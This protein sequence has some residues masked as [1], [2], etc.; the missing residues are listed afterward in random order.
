MEIKFKIYLKNKRNLGA[1][2]KDHVTYEHKYYYL[3][4]QICMPFMYFS[5]LTTPARTSNTMLNLSGMSK[6]ACLV[7]DL[8]GK[9]SIFHHWI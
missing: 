9:L 3:F 4:F 8:M 2:W 6:H 5:C 7:P 1:K